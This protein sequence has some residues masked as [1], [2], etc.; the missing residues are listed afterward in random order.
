MSRRV[1][2]LVVVLWVVVCEGG[3][4]MDYVR[5]LVGVK[6]LV[7]RG[8]RRMGMREVGVVWGQMKDAEG[9][10][11]GEAV[12]L[13][14]G[15]REAV[16]REIER[17]LRV[18]LG[19][20]R[21]RHWKDV[22]SEG[23]VWVMGVMASRGVFRGVVGGGVRVV[24]GLET[25]EGRKALYREVLGGIGDVS[26][27]GVGAGIGG[28]GGGVCGDGGIGG[29]AIVFDGE[30]VGISGGGIEQAAGGGEAA[31]GDGR[32]CDEEA[33]G[34]EAGGGE[35]EDDGVKGARRRGRGRGR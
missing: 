7:E 1:V 35:G 14:R 2:V 31:A 32:G 9:R 21:Q 27:V 5:F 29:E 13:V 24:G 15:I 11:R 12:G 19:S 8:V 20:A 17:R 26:G 34:G 18:W 28:D 10:V 22:D 16:E 25:G 4:M 30:A 3:V 23:L 6:E 33:G